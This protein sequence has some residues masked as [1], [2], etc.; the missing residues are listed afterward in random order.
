MARGETDPASAE[1]A[2]FAAL[3]AESPGRSIAP[4]AAARRLAADGEDWHRH[5]PAVK[6]AAR[7]LAETGRITL[8]RHG[9]PVAPEN[10]RGVVRLGRGS[11]G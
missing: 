1:D 3:D 7:R 8:L 11:D 4:E 2:I 9:K 10:M 6:A 5:L